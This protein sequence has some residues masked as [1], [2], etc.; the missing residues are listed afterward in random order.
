[1][2]RAG[3]CGACANYVFLRADGG[4]GNGHGPEYVSH[5]YEVPEAPAVAPAQ[6][7][8][9]QHAAYA[10]PAAAPPRTK[11]TG[12][13]VTLVIVAILLLCGCATGVAMFGG[14]IG[15]PL[16][17]FT[18]SDRQKVRAA[19]DPLHAFLT[20]NPIFDAATIKQIQEQSP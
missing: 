19:G 4:C 16:A 13:V 10:A 18:R 2:A 9:Y 7:P 20:A 6:P 1:M 3:W 15:D 5:V 11:R 14:A 12:L 8:A 17:V